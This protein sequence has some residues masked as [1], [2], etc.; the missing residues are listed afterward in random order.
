LAEYSPELSVL[1]EA[2]GNRKDWSLA[3]LLPHPFRLDISRNE[4]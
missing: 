1:A 4:R 2:G 3:E